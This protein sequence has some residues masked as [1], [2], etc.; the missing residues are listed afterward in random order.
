MSYSLAKWPCAA[1]VPRHIGSRAQN[2]AFIGFRFCGSVVAIRNPWGHAG[3][4]MAGI[5]GDRFRSWAQEGVVES[6]GGKRTQKHQ[7]EPA[8]IV[9]KLKYGGCALVLRGRTESQNQHICDFRSEAEARLWLHE[10][11]AKFRAPEAS[12]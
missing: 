8:F 6:F 2:A 12:G 10:N 3:K 11:A 7:F 5:L 9:K 1:E 4:R